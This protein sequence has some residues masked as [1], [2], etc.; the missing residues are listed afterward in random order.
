[1]ERT[2][3]DR[4]RRQ[5]EE[6]LLEPPLPHGGALPPGLLPRRPFA[7]LVAGAGVSQLGFWGFF[8]AILGQAGYRFHAGPFQ[9]GV[10]LSSF[11]LS[12]LVLTPVLGMATDRWS[13]KWMLVLGQVVAVAA[14]LPALFGSSLVWLYVASVI[15]GIG[16][17]ASIP[18]RGSMTALLVEEHELVRANGMLN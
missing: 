2:T 14:V 10:L 18:A 1:M 15:D 12:F 17:A 6:A 4:A 9:L 13:P 5:A 8:V 3:S 11:S 7:W 16:A